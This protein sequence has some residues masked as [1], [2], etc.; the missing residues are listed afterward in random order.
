MT[1]DEIHDPIDMDTALGLI[2]RGNQGNPPMAVCRKDDEP[3]IF[4]FEFPGAEFYCVVC[5][6][7][8]GFLGPKIADSTPELNARHE[9]LRAR[10]DNE[11]EERHGR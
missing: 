4:T 11:R 7:K 10:Y 2:A 9:V 1:D 3:L 5:Q 8:Y 6:S